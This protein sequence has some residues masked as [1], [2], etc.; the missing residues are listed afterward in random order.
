MALWHIRLEMHHQS[1]PRCSTQRRQSSHLG[2]FGSF[3]IFRCQKRFFCSFKFQFDRSFYFDLRYGYQKLFD[4]SFVIFIDLKDPTV[5]DFLIK[6]NLYECAFEN[7]IGL[8]TLDKKVFFIFASLLFKLGINNLSEQK[9]ISILVDNADRIPVKRV[10]EM[11]SKNKLYLHYVSS[12][13][14]KNE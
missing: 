7:A 1:G 11:L 8:I 13:S 3:V 2:V 9:A 10:V 14:N 12:R 5:F 6:H 4:K